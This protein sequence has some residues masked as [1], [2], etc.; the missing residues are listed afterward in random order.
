M[1]AKSYLKI[2]LQSTD[3]YAIKNKFPWEQEITCL[4]FFLSLYT[5]DNCLKSD[6]TLMKIS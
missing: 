2:Y 1:L 6:V 3:L 5:L 4:H